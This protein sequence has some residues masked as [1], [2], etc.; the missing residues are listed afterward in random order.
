MNEAANNSARVSGQ[1]RKISPALGT[2]QIA[3]FGGFRPLSSLEKIK[4]GIEFRVFNFRAIFGLR[5]LNFAKFSKNKVY[6]NHQNRSLHNSFDAKSKL[7]MDVS[8][9]PISCTVSARNI[10]MLSTERFLT[11]KKE[12]FI[13][14]HN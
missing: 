1:D 9:Y 11:F 14:T 10:D 12:R 8:D 13:T 2:N 7:K 3:G 5:V 6:F 4:N